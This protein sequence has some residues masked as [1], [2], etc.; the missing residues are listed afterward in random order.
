MDP[1]AARRVAR[2]TTRLIPQAEAPTRHPRR[3][4]AGLPRVGERLTV[5]FTAV[6]PDGSALARVGPALLAVPFGVPGEDAIVEVV[7]AGR[8]GRGRLV[9]I[10]RKSPD[11]VKPRCSHFGRCG[12]CQWQHLGLEA[13]RRLKTRLARDYLRERAEVRRDAVRDVLG[14][15]EGWAYRNTLRA[16][17][18]QRDGVAVLGYHVAGGE[19]VLD[20]AECPVQ[21]PANEAILRAARHAVR[22][23]G[24]PVYDPATGQGLVRGVMGMVSFAAGQALLTLST[25]APLTRP[26]DLVH[27]L[28]D[29]TP[30]LVGILHTIQ[31]RPSLELVG[32]RLRLLWGRDTVEEEVAGLRFR[33]RP[34]TALPANARAMALL[35]DVVRRAAAVRPGETVLDLTAATPVC[36]LALAPAAQAAIGIA[37]TRR[38]LEDARDAARQNGVTNAAFYSGH[39]LAELERLVRRGMRPTTVLLTSEGPGL[40]AEVVHAVAAAAPRRVVAVARS[41]A[42]CAH[43]VGRWRAVGYELEEVQPLDLLP[44]T[45]HVHLVTTLRPSPSRRPRAS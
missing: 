34:T 44:Q 43:D 40:A 30:G 8:R 10:L 14:G 42:A 12:G 36:V 21:H 24:L 22:T 5:R 1:P 11:I 35:I 39:P 31:P 2:R 4:G 19:R 6:A 27:A 18:A 25:A 41:L 45:S 37:P 17:F 20:V 3:P 29:R 26:T 16:V 28:I 9:A 23:L 15:G 7:Q 32:P 38:I 33:L 13:Q